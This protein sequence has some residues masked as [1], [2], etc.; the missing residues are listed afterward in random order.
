MEFDDNINVTEVSSSDIVTTIIVTIAYI[1]Y[2]V[3]LLRIFA[4]AF[5]FWGIWLMLEEIYSGVGMNTPAMIINASNAWVI[6]IPVI[7]ILTRFYNF[8]QNAVW[9]TMMLSGVISAIAFYIYYRRGQWL[10]VKV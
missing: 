6:Q 4:I 5:P 9:W 1:I 3:I 7:F 2:G 10:E 8:D